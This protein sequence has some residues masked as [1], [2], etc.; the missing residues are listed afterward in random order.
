MTVRPVEAGRQAALFGLE[1]ELV[2]LRI[3]VDPKLLE[4]LL[5]A[6][7]VLDFPINPQLFHRPSQVTVEFP[8]YSSHVEEVRAA[9]QGHGFNP[10]SLQSGSALAPPA[11]S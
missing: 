11:T 4:D 10:A 2:S 5:E 8:A 7:A 1:G 3:S 6:L 9:L